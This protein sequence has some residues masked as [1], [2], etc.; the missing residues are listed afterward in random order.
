MAAEL[1]KKI[2]MGILGCAEI[3]RK[4]SRSMI[5]APNA[6]VYAIGSRSIEKAT[7]FAKEN[8][9]PDSTKIY[10]SYEAV[11]DDLEVDAVYIPLPTS[12]HV[13]WACLAAEKKKHLLLEKPV[14][15]NV[16]E[17]DVIVEACE[18]HGVQIMDCTM[19]VHHPR[20]AVMKD[21]LKDPERFGQLKSVKQI[22]F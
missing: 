4:V 7:K 8:N 9:F 10:G 11:L 14:A 6:N 15:L 21:F 13:K 17:F 22:L 5:L 12:L 19:W 3:A 16:Q 20:T 1:K 18:A 2:N